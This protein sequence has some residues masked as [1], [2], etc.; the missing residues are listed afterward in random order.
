MLLIRAFTIVLLA[1]LPAWAHAISMDPGRDWQSADSAHFRVHYIKEQR[2]Q[3]ERVSRAAERAY[4]RITQQ[5]NWKPRGRTEIVLIDQW[6]LSNGYATPIPFNTVG[7]FIA[8]PDDGEL[9]TNSDWLEMLLTHELTHTVQLDKVR[10]V[11]GVLQMIFGRNLYFFPNLFQPTWSVEGLAVYNESDPK[12]GRGRLQGPAFE[13]W[14][15]AESQ[16]GFISLRELNADGRALPISKAYLYGAYFQE[17][18]V[19]RFGADALSEVV[20]RFSGNPPFW[21][22]VDSSLRPLTGQSLAEV[23]PEFLADLQQQVKQRNAAL[24]SVPEAAGTRVGTTN[25]FDIGA[26]AAQPDGSAL[27]VLDDGVGETAMVRI[28]ADGS[29]KKLTQVNAGTRI[30]VAADGRVLLTQPDVCNW[31]YLVYDVYRMD[32]DGDTHRV[33]HCARL[34]RAVQAGDRIVGLQQDG[35]TTRAVL[36]DDKGKQLRVLSAPTADTV[37]VDLAASPDGRY[38]ALLSKKGADW[39]VAQFDL[40]QPDAAPSPLFG[41]DAPLNNLRWTAAGLEF[42]ASRDRVYNVWRYQDGALLRLTHSHTGVVSAGGT[43]ADGSML[44]GVV[45]PGGYE[46]RRVAS[47]TVAQRVAVASVQPVAIPAE[48]PLTGPAAQPLG[49]GFGYSALRSIYPRTW[50]PI[51]TADQGL[52]SYG[53]AFSGG[54]ALGWHQYYAAVE[55]ETSQNEALGAF[56]YLFREQHLLTFQ[57]KLTPRAW[58]NND[59]DDGDVIAYDRETT[60]QWLSLLP[61]WKLERRLTFGVGAAIDTVDRVD[62]RGLFTAP[63]LDQRV[64]AALIEYD[65]SNTNWWAEGPNR[66]QRATLLYEDYKPFQRNDN[67]YDGNVFRLD[68]RG[69]LGVGRSVIALRYTEAKAQGR[70]ER[71]QLG[72]ATDLQLQFGYVLNDRDISLRG[73]RG[74][75][76]NLR[77]ANARVASLEF[78]TPLLDIDRHATTP[79]VGINRLSGAVFFDIGGA[80]DDG[81]RPDTYRRGVGVE[82]LAELK[83]LYVLG[84]QL[85]LGLARGLDEP[86]ETRGYLNVGHAF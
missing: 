18:L 73:Y 82:A 83:L 55:Y 48:A 74:D 17:Y 32:A 69:Y 61:W 41:F 40:Q 79:A 31:H 51:A 26:V 72:G 81:N 38:V 43:Q 10:G 13:A 75:E 50:F 77:G 29:Q 49:Q 34:R 65:T 56:Q 20:E 5:L 28:A 12:T 68:W 53:A 76:P 66:G 45:S 25:W 8:P 19:R 15:R 71:F 23:W 6:D 80:W 84:V 4:V 27:A 44:I 70:T 22:R 11:P 78:R 67:D 46:L 54:D 47:T 36:L 35:G 3:A 85:R 21:P 24:Y 7:V 39:K 58:E 42:I 62:P 59:K 33:T 64:L 86:K 30:D 57:R 14:L 16:R 2:D 52:T 9:L 63:P 1:L 60:A 37:L